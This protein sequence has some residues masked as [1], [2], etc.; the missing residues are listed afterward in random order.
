MSPSEAR[1]HEVAESITKTHDEILREQ[2]WNE[3][4]NRTV[5]SLSA[6]SIEPRSIRMNPP[7]FDGTA[8]CTILYTGS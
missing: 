1:S 5:E 3:A 6:R 8:A 2:A 4:L 7:K